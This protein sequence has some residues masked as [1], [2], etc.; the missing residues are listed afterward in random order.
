MPQWIHPGQH[1]SGAYPIYALLFR[2]GI[3]GLNPVSSQSDRSLER[4]LAPGIPRCS[5]I[6]PQA[7]VL[8]FDAEGIKATTSIALEDE[9]RVRSEAS[10]DLAETERPNVPRAARSRSFTGSVSTSAAKRKVV[11]NRT[12]S[13]IGLAPRIHVPTTRFGSVG[14]D[15]DTTRGPPKQIHAV[16]ATAPPNAFT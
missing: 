1:D 7:P 15:R 5:R 10:V 4:I 12:S 16:K 8:A 13:V 2:I 3:H 6:H 9:G 11:W 14:I